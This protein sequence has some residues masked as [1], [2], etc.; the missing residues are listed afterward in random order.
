MV[1]LDRQR[2]FSKGDIE[3]LFTPPST[4]LFPLKSGPSEA[5]KKYQIKEKKKKNS[6]GCDTII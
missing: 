5:Q 1:L 3:S 2:H 4:A 6:S